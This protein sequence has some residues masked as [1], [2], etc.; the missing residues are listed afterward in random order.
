MDV[1]IR[2]ATNQ[3]LVAL[4]ELYLE[5]HEFHVQRVP[6]RLRSLLAQGLLER[7]ELQRQIRS[8]LHQE[9]ALLLVAEKDGSLVGLAELYLR[10]DDRENPAVVAHRYAHLQSLVVTA[11]ARHNKVGQ[12][13]LEAAEA[14]AGANGAEEVRLDIWEFA[15]GPRRIPDP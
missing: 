14:W 6:E 5:F 13:M 2:Q 3:H 11:R 12:S 7:E 1:R 8:I 10:E 15:A 4:G 9:D